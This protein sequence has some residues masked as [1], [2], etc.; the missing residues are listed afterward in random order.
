MEFPKI[1]TL[2]DMD[3]T[4]EVSQWNLIELVET[5]KRKGFYNGVWV[6]LSLVGFFTLIRSLIN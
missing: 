4:V 2:D 5:S 3:K 6:G 1:N